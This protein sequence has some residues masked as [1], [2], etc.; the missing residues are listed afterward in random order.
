MVDL[1]YNVFVSVDC[2]DPTPPTGYIVVTVPSTTVGSTVEFDCDPSAGYTGSSGSV[3]CQ[4]S[5]NWTEF[6]G[7]SGKQ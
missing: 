5:G 1:K 2:D 7:C 4:D 6:T 3:T